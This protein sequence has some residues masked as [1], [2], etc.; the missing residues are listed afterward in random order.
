MGLERKRI[1]RTNEPTETRSMAVFKL[2][3][4]NTL[5]YRDLPK[6]AWVAP[7]LHLS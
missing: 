6:S 1:S 3:N 4:T 7:R 5:R 2:L